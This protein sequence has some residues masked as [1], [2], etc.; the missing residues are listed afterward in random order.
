[1]LPV[2]FTRTLDWRDMANSTLQQ[3]AELDQLLSDIS[4]LQD[5][6]DPV[7]IS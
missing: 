3:I 2:S 6:K 4:C 7:N 5:P 1:M